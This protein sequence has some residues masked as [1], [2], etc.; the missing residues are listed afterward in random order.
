[1]NNNSTTRVY[2]LQPLDARKSFYGK[3]RV[4]EQP[5]ETLELWSYATK[6]AESYRG[7]IKVFGTCSPTTLRHIKSFIHHITRKTLTKSEIEDAYLVG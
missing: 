1:M 5:D 3:C 4:I 7:D 2:E 6:V